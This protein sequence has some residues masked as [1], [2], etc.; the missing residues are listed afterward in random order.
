M[1]DVGDSIWILVSKRLSEWPYTHAS[2][3]TLDTLTTAD[4]FRVKGET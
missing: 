4:A 3:Q 1:T 2:L